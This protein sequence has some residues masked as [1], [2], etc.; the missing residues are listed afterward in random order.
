MNG[1]ADGIRRVQ[2]IDMRGTI[3][4]MDG[5]LAISSGRQ[6]PRNDGTDVDGT[7]H[8]SVGS[9]IVLVPIRVISAPLL[10]AAP[11][12]YFLAD[13]ISAMADGPIAGP[14]PLGCGMSPVFHL[15]YWSGIAHLGNIPENDLTG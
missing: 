14:S 3:A 13:P 15:R 7:A 2:R 6:T 5:E 11:A 8:V 12:T 1:D 10:V 9:I 4:T